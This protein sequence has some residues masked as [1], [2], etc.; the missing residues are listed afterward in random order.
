MDINL[1]ATRQMD[2]NQHKQMLVENLGIFE[3]RALGREVGV[4]S[5]TTK[6]RN[7]LI[8]LILDRIYNNDTTLVKHTKK[9][10]PFKKLSNLEDIMAKMTGGDDT[11][12]MI[13]QRKP[14]RYEDIVC[15]SQDV[16]VYT[17]VEDEDA[18]DFSGILRKNDVVACLLDRK[19]LKKVFVPQR[20]TVVYGLQAGD[21]ID[22]E[23]IRVNTSEDYVM[24]K[25]YKINGVEVGKYI[26]RF[27]I[28]DGPMISRD[29]LQYGDYK[30]YCGRRNLLKYNGNL[31]EDNRFEEF[32]TFCK[33]NN[34]K[35]ITLGL[36]TCFEDQIM[37]SEID[38]MLDMTTVYGTGY[39]ISF[40]KVID[41]IAHAER[42]LTQGEK[43]VLFVNDIVG[44]LNVLDKCFVEKEM[45]SGHKER[46]VV[47]AQKLVSLGKALK[48][49]ASITVV[50]TY[51]SNNSEDLFFKNELE[52]ISSK[53]ED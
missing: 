21:L 50:M 14:L 34:Y 18:T 35:L 15:F 53:F 13:T 46:G 7:D 36:N 29:R 28:M 6:K 33:E 19:T 30:L 51:W 26:P 49:G 42:L 17:E 22:C 48:N 12:N 45:Q 4:P 38:N 31:F 9:G 37:F 5:P 52:K 41:A 2:R 25:I 3:L 16:P 1:L 43:V 44:M 8:E 10:R 47:I 11:D 27:E 23:G 39:D 40:G 24:S 32:A 20:E